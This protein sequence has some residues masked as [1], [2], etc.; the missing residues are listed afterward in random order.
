MPHSDTQ[1]EYCAIRRNH[2]GSAK[3]LKYFDANGDHRVE[4][5]QDPHREIAKLGQAGWELVTLT[6]LTSPAATVYY[7][8]REI[9]NN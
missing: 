8:K 9:S 4:D 7:L 1:F 2:D 5:I 6:D 3:K